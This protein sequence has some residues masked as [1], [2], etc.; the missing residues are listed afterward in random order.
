[1]GADGGVKSSLWRSTVLVSLGAVLGRL[2][3]VG[4]EAVFAHYFGANL[5]TDAYLVAVLI[6]YLIQNVVAGG[7][8]Q[9]ALVP[10]V[11]D[12]VA[13]G[14]REAAAR[15]VADLTVTVAVVMMAVSVVLAL[16]AGPITR[17][18][19]SGFGPEAAAA[20]A[21]ILRWCAGLIV[22]NGVL[23]VALGG[24]NTFGEFSTT[25]LLSPVLN[26]VQ[27]VVMIALAPVLGISA[28]VAGLLAGTLAQ[29]AQQLRPLGQVGVRLSRG[30]VSMGLCQRLLPAFIPAALASLVAQGNPLAD[31]IIGSYLAPGSITHLNY[32]DLFAGSIAIVTT[33]VALVTFPVMSVAVAEGD[34]ERAR[35]TLTC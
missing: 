3:G 10:L 23:A 9:A 26:G 21:S 25:A 24:L 16:C 31:K 12:E 11:A 18:T 29:C 14:G 30:R 2:L 32:A 35:C 22:L 28:A 5:L 8:L 6:P 7:S 20:A 27:I 1:M 34:Q 19:A 15:F 4:R 33:T 13:R 17:V